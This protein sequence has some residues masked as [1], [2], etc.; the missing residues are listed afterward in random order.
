MFLI[1]CAF[2]DIGVYSASWAQKEHEMPLDLK[3][4]MSPLMGVQGNELRS[5]RR[6]ESVIN[7]WAISSICVPLFLLVF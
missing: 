6:A 5:S 3:K 7:H 4:F 2:I 1:I